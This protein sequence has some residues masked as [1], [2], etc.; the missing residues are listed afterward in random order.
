MSFDMPLEELLQYQ[1]SSPKPENFDEYWRA[2][3]DELDNTPPEPRISPADFAVPNMICQDLWFNGVRGGHIHAR[4]VRPAGTENKPLPAILHYHGYTGGADA[5]TYIMG[6]AAAGLAVFYMECRGQGGESYDDN[7]N[8]GRTHTSHLLK[9]ILDGDPQR[10]ALRHAMLDAT[11]LARI[12]MNMT[13]IDAKH[14]CTF[15]ESQGGALALAC[16]ALEPRI[17]FCVPSLPW[18]CDFKR[19]YELQLPIGGVIQEITVW[20]RTHD[21]QHK[22]GNWLFEQLAYIDMQNLAPRINAQVLLL[23]ALKDNN[24]PPSTQFAMYNKLKSKKEYLLFHDFVHE[25]I[26][27]KCDILLQWILPKL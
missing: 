21:P 12:A 8:K 27:N 2:A 10:L 15:G 24:C 26:L 14:I 9:G 20:F 25:P 18:L 23:C 22:T 3:L 5:W 6:L 19:T 7:G 13:N 4:Y 17:A 1:G 11:Q 16:A